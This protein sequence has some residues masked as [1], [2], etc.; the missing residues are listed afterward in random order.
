MKNLQTKTMVSLQQRL[1]DLQALFSEQKAVDVVCIDVSQQ[2]GGGF[3]DRLFVL[4]ATSPRH[5]RSIA[6][7]ISKLC[8]DKAY[9]YL[10]V[11]GYQV[12]EWVLVDLNDIIVS[13][14]LESTRALYRIEDLWSKLPR[15][16]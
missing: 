5:A 13:I 2:S 11:E 6:D 12:G 8:H 4:T 7:A 14:F 10:G 1:L 9:D 15:E 3:A 16:E